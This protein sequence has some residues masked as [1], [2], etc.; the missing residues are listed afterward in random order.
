MITQ[1]HSAFLA[2]RGIPPAFALAAGLRTLQ[3][4]EARRL[5]AE[6]EGVRGE[7]L[8]IP[9]P[10]SEASCGEPFFRVRTF[11]TRRP[12]EVRPGELPPAH[13]PVQATG[14]L[15][16]PANLRELLHASEFL[17]V[18]VDEIRAIAATAHGLACVALQSAHGWRDE[19]GA[20]LAQ[21]VALTKEKPFV[22]VLADS[23]ARGDKSISA[24]LTACV[25]TLRAKVPDAKVHYD[26]VPTP[27][28]MRAADAE[29]MAKCGL[30]DW[31]ARRSVED[32]RA[33]LGR[34]FKKPS[35]QA[36]AASDRLAERG[37][38][39][40][41][42]GYDGDTYYV[43]SVPRGQYGAYE[44]TALYKTATIASICG[45]GWAERNFGYTTERG[46]SVDIQGAGDRIISECMDR[47]LFNPDRIRCAGVWDA[48]DALI[49][50]SREFF[51]S[52]GDHA[53]RVGHHIYTKTRDI[54]I[55]SQDKPCTTAD[56]A[57]IVEA[58]E[59][60]PWAR[61][62]DGLALFGWLTIAF[63]PGALHWRPMAYVNAEANAGKSHLL[64]FCKRLL[65]Q[66][67][68][69]LEKT[70]P[71]G[72]TQEVKKD[73]L[74]LLIDETE[75]D[76]KRIAD[77]LEFLRLSAS[78]ATSTK[79]Q[80][81]HQPIKFRLES[82]GLVA[83]TTEPSLNA[84]DRTR[85]VMFKFGDAGGDRP[86]NPLLREADLK[87][88]GGDLERIGRGLFARMLQSWQRF[89]RV[90]DQITRVMPEGKKRMYDVLAPVIAGAWVALH[91][92]EG[93]TDEEAREWFDRFDLVA[94][95]ERINGSSQGEEVLNYLLT[96]PIN[97]G[98]GVRML[99]G[100]MI[101]KSIAESCRGEYTS[102]LG[103]M[104]IKARPGTKHLLVQPGGQ[105][106][107]QLFKGS[108][109]ANA[110]T[111]GLV[112]SIPGASQKTMG[113]AKFIPGGH[114]QRYYT[115][116][117]DPFTGDGQE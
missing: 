94:D 106:F 22:I 70:S 54:G 85:Y 115:V 41:A 84:A 116:P 90:Q 107:K 81:N 74:A 61:K 26:R 59:L 2:A 96:K 79:G 89:Q 67:G 24:A 11:E 78:G 56:A 114:P 10:D 110:E 63:L 28:E 25:D 112:R 42:L 103:R 7:A 83:G 109:W 58:L 35:D 32:V 40:M 44:A 101:E 12:E 51:R 97:L 73:S 82:I 53:D 87:A 69:L 55:T 98:P 48:G 19:S 45:P 76:G 88:P 9:Y 57:R 99:I 92:A 113:T 72:V 1:S 33:Q 65:G 6:L 29:K 71:A 4:A 34:H 17:I 68:L 38:G 37:E 18:T 8:H 27:R 111:A 14:R 31:L 49:V 108:R 75:P 80:A 3:P 93:M 50:N 36:K 21:L 102:E 23:D 62:S 95:M 91:D 66:A 43:F 30:D 104:G 20:P 86:E 47:D 105:G 15:Y 60:L 39:Y 5:G 64:R 16:Q 117:F 100:E 13:A 52:D 46:R 77:M